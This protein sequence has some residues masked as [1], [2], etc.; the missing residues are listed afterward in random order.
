MKTSFLE[1]LCCPQD[2]SHLELQIFKQ[3][4]EEIIEGL[5]T[6]PECKRYYPIIYGIPIMT[7]DEYRQ[8]ELEEPLLK[9]WGLNLTDSG[10]KFCLIE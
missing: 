7:P 2:K 5:F 6:C 10:S 8:K 9:K 3:K 4:D 1:K